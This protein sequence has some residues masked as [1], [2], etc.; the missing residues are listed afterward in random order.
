MNDLVHEFYSKRKSIPAENLTCLGSE[1]QHMF[2]FILLAGPAII[3]MA[4]NKNCT[5]VTQYL[6]V[7]NN[8]CI[9]KYC[10]QINY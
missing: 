6:F 8:T 9:W 7:R 2:L 10:M 3:I 1:S 5:K 4:V